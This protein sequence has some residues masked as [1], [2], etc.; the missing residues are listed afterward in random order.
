M[1]ISGDEP[2]EDESFVKWESGDVA[3]ADVYGKS[4]TFVMPDKE[5]GQ[6]IFAVSAQEKKKTPHKGYLVRCLCFVASLQQE[7]YEA[8][9]PVRESSR[10]VNPSPQDGMA[11]VRLPGH[12]RK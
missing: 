9:T 10:P 12:Q 5:L 6:E 3:L 8:A 11:P 1:T 7:L 4:T 2:A